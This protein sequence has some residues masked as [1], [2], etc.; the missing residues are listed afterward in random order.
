MLNMLNFRLLNDTDLLLNLNTHA[1][2][3]IMFYPSRYVM[4]LA[5]SDLYPVNTC[6]GQSVATNN[7]IYFFTVCV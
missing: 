3:R 6:T 2:A 7:I 1:R 5:C 4:K